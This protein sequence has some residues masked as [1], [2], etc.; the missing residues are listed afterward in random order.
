MQCPEL[1]EGLKRFK[2]FVF[3]TLLVAGL[4]VMMAGVALAQSRKI[5]VEPEAVGPGG[6][7]TLS[8]E[9]FEANSIVKITLHGHSGALK[10]ARTDATGAFSVDVVTPADMLAGIHMLMVRDETGEM[11]QFR[12]TIDAAATRAW[13]RTTLAYIVGGVSILMLIAGIVGVIMIHRPRR[14]VA[15]S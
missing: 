15:V 13:P 14:T 5:H 9:G 2:R 4:L 10:V 11:A 6:T 8:G 3:S 7:V 1:V 12:L